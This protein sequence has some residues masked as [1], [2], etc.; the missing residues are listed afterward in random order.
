MAP[1]ALKKGLELLTEQIGEGPPV[2]KHA[3]YRIKLKMWL[4]QGDPVRWNNPWGLL[5]NGAHLEEAELSV[6]R[7]LGNLTASCS[8]PFG[9]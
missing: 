8:E 9:P 6:I 3:S 7:W 2:R 5:D 1:R 4:H